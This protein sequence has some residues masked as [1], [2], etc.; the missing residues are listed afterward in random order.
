MTA[1][2]A[3]NVTGAVRSATITFEG[4]PGLVQPGD[5]VYVGRWGRGVQQHI[6]PAQPCCSRGTWAGG[7]VACEP[8]YTQHA[9]H[10]WA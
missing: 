7:A 4:L 1:A 6:V 10:A 3:R 2:T 9:A 5:V 8:Q